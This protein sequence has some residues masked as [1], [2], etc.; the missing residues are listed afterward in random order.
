MHFIIELSEICK[1]SIK[2]NNIHF[3]T[4]ISKLSILFTIPGSSTAPERQ[5]KNATI[6]VVKCNPQFTVQLLV[7]CTLFIR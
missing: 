6:T 5:L 7:L 3:L 4:K 1:L 2:P